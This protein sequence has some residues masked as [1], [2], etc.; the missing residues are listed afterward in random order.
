MALLLSQIL[1]FVFYFFLCNLKIVVWCVN[2]CLLLF[3]HILLLWSIDYDN[4]I[5]QKFLNLKCLLNYIKWFAY[6]CLNDEITKWNKIYMWITF[7][8]HACTT[9]VCWLIDLCLKAPS[10]PWTWICQCF[11]T[12]CYFIGRQILLVEW[13]QVPSKTSFL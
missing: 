6:K 2:G 13:S 12:I 11:S 3:K 8:M 7:Y 10:T 9:S 5:R 4:R 1:F